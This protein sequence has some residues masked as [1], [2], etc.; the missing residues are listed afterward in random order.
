MTLTSNFLAR[1]EQRRIDRG[2]AIIA[3]DAAAAFAAWREEH[4]PLY[5]LPIEIAA[6]RYAAFAL[7]KS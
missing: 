7:S 4:D 2:R 3:A 5:R 1:L 6:E